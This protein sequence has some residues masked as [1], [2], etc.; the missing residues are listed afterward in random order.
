LLQFPK[1]IIKNR[2]T[3]FT[4]MCEEESEELYRLGFHDTFSSLYNEILDEY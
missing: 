3:F 1:S 2:Y 4:L